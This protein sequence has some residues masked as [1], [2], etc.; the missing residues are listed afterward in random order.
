[1]NP[2]WS[3]L[4]RRITS[5]GTDRDVYGYLGTGMPRIRHLIIFILDC[6]A[7][8]CAQTK[9]DKKKKKKKY[10]NSNKKSDKKYIQ[11]LNVVTILIPKMCLAD[12]ML[13]MKVQGRHDKYNRRNLGTPFSKE[14]KLIFGTT[15][16]KSLRPRYYLTHSKC[17]PPHFMIFTI[18]NLWR[19]YL[20]WCTES[21]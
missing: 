14:N 9:R 12:L 19:L 6:P 16:Q 13:H 4:I 10:G 15:N 11:D 1:M 5:L 20:L 21:L 2:F 7:P 18:I 8:R 3:V 17:T